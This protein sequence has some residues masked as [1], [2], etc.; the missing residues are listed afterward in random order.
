MS[1][2][3]KVDISAMSVE[4]VDLIA[5]N[6]G[7]KVNEILQ[8]AKDEAEKYLK[9]YGLTLDLSYNIQSSEQQPNQ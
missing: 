9:V 6:L 8:K 2:E 3:R 7:V 5:Q 4:Q 1:R